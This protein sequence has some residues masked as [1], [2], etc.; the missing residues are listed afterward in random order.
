MAILK[1]RY[2]SYLKKFVCDDNHDGKN[3]TC[4]FRH[5]Y[6]KEFYSVIEED[7][8]RIADAAEFRAEF[9][10]N[11]GY[12]EPVLNEPI[13]V[14]EVMVALADRCEQSIMGNFEY[15]DRTSEWFW[16]M[17]ESLG[18]L[19]FDDYNYDMYFVDEI[20]DKMLDREYEP[21]GRGGLFYIEGFDGDL[22]NVEIWYQLNYWLNTIDD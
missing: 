8:N 18:L 21:D 4:I 22:R 3:Y 20:I 16:Y 2:F 5:L 19:Y 17:I 6:N 9:E 15:G 13:S 12:Y 10:R 14:L 7:D 1:K 11:N